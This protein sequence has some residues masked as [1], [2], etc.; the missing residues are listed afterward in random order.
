MSFGTVKAISP[1]RLFIGVALLLFILIL[2]WFPPQIFYFNISDSIPFGLYFRIS[3]DTL[4]VGD[5]VAYQ[6]T[7]DVVAG[8]RQRGWIRDGQEPLFL[9]YIGGLP[10]D[11][12]SSS[13]HRFFINGKY[14]GDILDFDTKGNPLPQIQG[15]F[16]VP[17]QEFLPLA[18]NPEG[19]DGRYTGCVPI[20]RIVAKVVPVWV[21]N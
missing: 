9:K 4:A 7:D 15:S 6:P 20:D 12:F 14:I 13:N 2:I 19:F 17:V 10:G 8:M 1:K 3:S 5:I 18:T 16:Q 21:V 11:T